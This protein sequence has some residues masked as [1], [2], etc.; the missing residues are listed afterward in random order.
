M[1]ISIWDI[2]KYI[3]KWKFFIAFAVIVSFVLSIFYVNMQQSYNAQVI[4]RYNDSCVSRGKT[5]NETDFDCYEIVSPDVLTA[6]IGDLSLTKSVDSIRSRVTVTPIIPD[7]EKAVQAS[8]EKDGEIYEYYPNTFSVSYEGKVG[9][10][11]SLSRDILDSIVQNYLI[12]YQENY[13]NQAY[14]NDVSFDGDIGDYDYIEVAEIISDRIDSTISSLEGYYSQDKDFR[15]PTTGLTFTDIKNDYVHLQEYTVS[16]LFA[17]IYRGQITKDKALL[18]QKYT[19]R[20]EDYQLKQ[21]NFGELAALTKDRMDKFAEANKDVPNAYNNATSDNNDNIAL[22]EDIHGRSET[23]KIKTETTYDNLVESYIS[24]AKAENNSRLNAEHCEDVIDKFAKPMTEKVDT[25][26]L[27]TSIEQ[28][29][30][31]IKAEMAILYHSLSKTIDD[32]NDTT[33][34]KHIDLLT[35]VHYYATKSQ[36][37]YTIIIVGVGGASSVLIALAFE[38]YK[39]TKAL[40]KEKNVPEDK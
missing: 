8:K 4:I 12:Y 33:A 1:K 13:A 16:N 34:A 28:Q 20:K 22:L 6:V 25:Q 14:I 5:A 27:T 26:Q 31:D 9:E 3:F 24:Y 2:F 17:D 36:W 10:P 11:E 39:G 32:Y 40:K 7:S 15:A 30:V 23:Y 35:G 37:L 19:E 38:V 18:I 29:I 21:K